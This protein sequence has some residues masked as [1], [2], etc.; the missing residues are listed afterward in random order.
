MNAGCR[1]DEHA[2]LIEAIQCLLQEKRTALKVIR[3]GIAAF[4]AQIAA[5]GYL[6]MAFHRYPFVQ[7]LTSLDGCVAL[8]MLL[9]S[10]AICLVVFGSIRLRR[11]DGDILIL[12]QRYRKMVDLSSKHDTDIG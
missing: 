9:L 2:L 7:A 6:I 1:T 11:L 12:N 8:G 10:I 3:V 4:T 5:T